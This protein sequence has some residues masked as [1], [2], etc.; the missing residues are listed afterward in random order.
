MM[1]AAG[2]AAAMARPADKSASGRDIVNILRGDS[3]GVVGRGFAEDKVMF[4]LK[5]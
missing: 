3:R 2:R 4:F 5:F 1:G